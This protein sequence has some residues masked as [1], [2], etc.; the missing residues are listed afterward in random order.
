MT[1]RR[2]LFIAEG[3]L[4]DL[5]L[6]TPAL[7]AARTSFPAATI[8]V[9]LV[10][11]RGSPVASPPL[12]GPLAADAGTALST[13]PNVDR[14]FVLRRH[15]LRAMRGV[16]RLRA[17]F[18][19]VRFVR[20]EKFDTVICTFPE[21]RFVLYAYASGAPVRVGQKGQPLGW[22]LTVTPATTKGRRGVRE[23]YCDLA[24]AIGATV[25]SDRTEFAVPESARRWADRTLRDAGVRKDD[26]LVLVHPGAT[27]DYKIWPPARFA[28]LLDKVARLRGVRPVLCAGPMDAPVVRAIR[29]ELGREPLVL[30]TGGDLAR[31]AALMERSRLCITN[32]SGPRHLAVALGA[33]SLAFFRQHHGREWKV[34][35]DS[36]FCVTLTGH[37]QC[38]L[39]P[40]GVCFDRVPPPDHFGSSCLRLIGV[41]EAYAAVTSMLRRRPAAGAPR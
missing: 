37:G 3:Q 1:P 23:Y 28:Q 31:L 8:S 9:M 2:I 17:E 20:R 35:P 24:R 12:R 15:V 22:L 21:D 7:R 39:C 6:L 5:L 41:D 26:R 13:N 29:G 32:D 16:A 10:E 30:D 4:G 34:Y 25:A 27:G 19:V 40:D 18:A 38:G 14:L 33:P 11:R 36:Q